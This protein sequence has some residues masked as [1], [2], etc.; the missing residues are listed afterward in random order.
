MRF[1]CLLIAEPDVAVPEPGSA[2][3]ADMLTE[4]QAATAAMAARGVLVDTGPLQP[5]A[6]STML[7]V[8][9]GQRRLSGGSFDAAAESIGGY[10]VLDC[11]DRDEAV[12]WMA[13]I[14]AARY[15]AIELRPLMPLPVTSNVLPADPAAG[16]SPAT[17][18][19]T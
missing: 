10:Y 3:F 9:D 15:G 12:T 19:V 6:E 17:G 14:P 7:R 5:A 2:E 16:P 1:L 13:T 8:R 18:L 4:F 11:A